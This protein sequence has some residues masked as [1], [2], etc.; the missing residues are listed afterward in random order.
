MDGFMRGQACPLISLRAK[1]IPKKE[2]N[3]L[4]GGAAPVGARQPIA[5]L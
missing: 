4:R 5:A 3:T 2:S 1:R